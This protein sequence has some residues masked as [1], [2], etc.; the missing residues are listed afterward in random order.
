MSI[1]LTRHAAYWVLRLVRVENCLAI[2]LTTMLGA[3]LAVGG[4]ALTSDRAARGA[5]VAV[6]LI[7]A[8]NVINDRLDAA[9]D[10]AARPT[11]PIPSGLVT[12]A[13]ADRM[14]AG[15]TVAALL[16][17]LSLGLAYAVAAA[18]VTAVSFGYSY[19]LKST[20]LLG[21]LVVA[22]LT[23]TTV[24]YGAW[25]VGAPGPL[26]WLAAGTVGLLMLSFEVLK[27]A[28]DHDTDSRHGI[29]TIST[30]FGRRA[31]I[32]A[33]CLLLL[34]FAAV[35]VL[36]PLFVETRWIHTPLAVGVLV[37]VAAGVVQL[38]NLGSGNASITACLHRI[39]VSWFLGILALAAL[40]P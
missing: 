24:V 21:N 13:T 20:V 38:L 33:G 7:G 8:G 14:F 3:Y 32:R 35:A 10:A 4:A 18:V 34:P 22:G 15:L 25:T 16:I 12:A 6:L 9:V 28:E 17:A 30:V 19:R 1:P 27:C 2:G 23:A 40:R 39:K 11:R 37:L 31:T 5:A 36:P 29:R 26:G